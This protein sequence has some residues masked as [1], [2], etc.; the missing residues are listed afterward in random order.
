MLYDLASE[1]P[2][3]GSLLESLFILMA[4]RRREAEYY[5][6]KVLATASIA[7]HSEGG[8][9]E[10][11]KAFESYQSSMFPFLADETKKTDKDSKKLLKSWT[12][13]ALKIKPL[14]R[15]Q[16]NKPLISKLRKG[17]EQVKKAEALRRK[18]DHRR[19]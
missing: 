6:T 9:K 3:P 12:N 10:L 19:I 1:P 16:E 11:E 8:G 2:R 5:K 18:K 15:A 13:K 7:A 14:W 4:K 17:A